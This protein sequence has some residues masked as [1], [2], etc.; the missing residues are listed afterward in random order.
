[1]ILQALVPHLLEYRSCRV[2]RILHDPAGS[3]ST[4]PGVQVLQGGE[5]PYT[6]KIAGA[7]GVNIRYHR[8]R[9]VHFQIIVVI[10][11]CSW[12]QQ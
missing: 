2:V 5:D 4:P 11:H 9:K 1:M 7:S 12:S 8:L 10:P 3:G 6:V